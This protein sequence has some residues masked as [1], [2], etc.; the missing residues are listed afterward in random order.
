MK[1]KTQFLRKLLISARGI[2]SLDVFYMKIWTIYTNVPTQKIPN[3]YHIFF[4][5]QMKDDKICHRK[6]K[7]K[8]GGWG[9][10]QGQISL[11]F[12]GAPYFEL[13]QST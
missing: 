12:F 9:S 13:P 1:L 7:K 5:A 2:K 11:T 6:M 10:E 8:W 4:L 3:R